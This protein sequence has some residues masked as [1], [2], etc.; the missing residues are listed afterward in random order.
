MIDDEQKQAVHLQIGRLLLKNTPTDALEEKVFEIVEHFNHSIE[1]LNNQVERLKI[2]ELNLM[3]GQ[4]AKMATAYEA[5][6]NYLTMGRECL[7]QN[8]WETGYDLTFKLFS[9]ATEV[10]YLNGDFEQMEQLA[11]VVLQYAQTLSDEAKICEIQILDYSAQNQK[12]KALKIA[13]AFLKK[14]DIHFPE[15][16]TEGE[17][18]F[19]LQTMQISLSNKSIRSFIDLPIM[20]DTHKKLAM[21]IMAIVIPITH[22]KS[23]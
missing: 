15:E 19:A 17:V 7:P 12:R 5:A 13:L 14:L 23:Y 10:A 22:H 6:I 18:G 1:L 4:K 8:T 3:A 9:E 21:H 16:P 20:K 2:A 11:Q